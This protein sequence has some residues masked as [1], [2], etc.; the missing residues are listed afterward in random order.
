MPGTTTPQR[1]RRSRKP[2]GKPNPPIVLLAGPEKTGKGH[3]AAVGTASDLVAMT[4]WLQVGG[5][6][7]TADYYGRIKGARYEIV[8]HDGSFADIL[9]AIRWAISRPPGAD[10]KRNMIVID[11]ISSVWDLLSDEVSQ[12]GRKRAERRAYAAG[13]RA[14]RLDDPFVDEE[15]DLW[16][17]A[18]DRWGEMLWLLRRHNGPTLLI[19]RQEISSVFEN[20]KPTQHTTRRIK[21]EKNIKAAVDAVVEFHAVGE[22]YVTG[23]HS[24]PEHWEIRPGWTYRYESVDRLLRWLGYEDAAE[25]RTVIE[26]RPEAYL[27]EQFPVPESPQRAPEPSGRERSRPD[28]GLTGAQ[29]VELIHRALTDKTDPEGR[30]Q[31]IR[32][33]WGS[34]ILRT[35]PT[36]T[37]MWGDMDADSLL[38][39]ALTHIKEESERKRQEQARAG[40]HGGAD[41]SSSQGE[42]DQPGTPPDESG[43][44]QAREHHETPPPQQNAEHQE[45]EEEPPTEGAVPP[46]PDPEAE[47]GPPPGETP[48]DTTEAEEPQDRPAPAPSAQRLADF[49]AGRPPKREPDRRTKI[50][51][52][53]LRAEAD[54]QARVLMCTLSEHLAP[55]SEEGDPDMIPLRNYLL[56]QRPKIIA[57]LEREGHTELAAYY[58]G[59]PPVDTQIRKAFAPYF[60]SAPA[61]Q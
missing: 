9:D 24:M 12:V 54:I 32:N 43:Q 51:L 22:A 11:D 48:E 5:N 55:I 49:A 7:S 58:R 27:E 23:T 10:G 37:R 25:T 29:A 13:Q 6:S 21:A 34:R 41:A 56:E 44:D 19:A 57:Q 33:E 42:R 2:T 4:Y 17:H 59:A 14:P 15:R 45:D 40:E 1:E 36:R 16:G 30:L 26:P 28:F 3:E 61:G 53:A 8:P 39:R 35:I 52:E 20:D 18:K 50:A 60:G 46:P 38:T 47:D 31:A